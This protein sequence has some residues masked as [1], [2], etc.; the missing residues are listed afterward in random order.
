Q[1]PAA[2]FTDATSESGVGEAVARHYI[3]Y[4]KWWLSGLNLVDLDGDGHLDLFLAAHGAGRALALLN[5][6]HGRFREADG[7][8]PLSEIHLAYDINE[9]GRLDLQM[10]WQDGGGKWWLNESVPGRLTFRETAITAGQGRANAIIDINRD[11]KADWL[12]ER[13]GVVF[14]LGDGKG[15]F[16]TGGNI[17]VAATRNEINIHPAD[18]NGD[19]FM[20]LALHWG[21][22]SDERGRSR[23]YFNDGKMNFAN[24]TEQAGL[25]EEGLAIKGIGDVNQDGRPDLLA[26]D[27]RRPELFL[28]DGKGRF[29]RSADALAGMESATKPR[30]VSWGLAVVAD[31][32]NDGTADI[33]WN[34]RHFLWLLRGTGGGRF[35]YMNRVW[36]IEDKSA[37]S[38]DDGLCF[39]DIDGD[40]DLDIIGYTGPLDSHRLVK[41][42]RND[43]AAGNWLRVRVVGAAGNRG[44]AGA[45]IRLA[46][47]GKPDALLAFEQVAILDSQSAHSYYSVVPTERHFGLGNRRAVDVSVEFYPSGKRVRRPANANST[48]IISEE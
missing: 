24:A 13:P 34:G 37:A 14:E 36:G 44:A 8:Y 7:V 23:V 47:A 9:D 32:D 46:E 1:K 17:E 2:V 6:G 5:D 31:F 18:L 30:Y 19:G 4:P 39:G 3:K 29:T 11:G 22:Y 10:T 43:C 25:R 12:H 16:M 21:R 35:A 28:N 27:N 48:V 26:L 33:L 15:G 38:V 40:G 20:D 41:V 42:Y 45:K